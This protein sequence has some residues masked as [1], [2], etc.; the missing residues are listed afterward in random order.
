MLLHRSIDMRQ[1]IE[2]RILQSQKM[3]NWKDSLNN[4]FWVNIGLC[5]FIW[6]RWTIFI[7]NV[8]PAQ[9]YNS[10]RK[11]KQGH[12]VRSG[13]IIYINFD[14]QSQTFCPINQNL[15]I[16][17]SQRYEINIIERLWHYKGT[18]LISH[19]QHNSSNTF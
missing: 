10:K 9:I 7:Q 12:S 16:G 17:T 5:N 6:T 4:Y 8:Y 13:E 18:I 1:L 14:R 3:P 11:K 2:Q 19:F 15:F